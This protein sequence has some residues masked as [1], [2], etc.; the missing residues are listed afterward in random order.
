M[1]CAWLGPLNASAS[2]SAANTTKANLFGRF[3]LSTVMPHFLPSHSF[4]RQGVTGDSPILPQERDSRAGTL[5][6]PPEQPEEAGRHDAPIA[7]THQEVDGRQILL[8][9]ARSSRLTGVRCHIPVI[10]DDQD[11]R[12]ASRGYSFRAPLRV[13]IAPL[14][15]LIPPC[16][17]ATPYVFIVAPPLLLSIPRVSRIRFF[18]G[19][20]GGGDERLQGESGLPPALEPPAQRVAILEAVGSEAEGHPGARRLS[21]LRAVEDHLA[22]GWDQVVGVL[23]RFGSDP[24]R[25]RNSVRSRFDIQRHSQVNDH[26]VVAS[27]EPSLELHR[28]DASLP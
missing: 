5:T 20:S 25:P 24:V 19:K 26:E 14:P 3:C 12:V 10:P 22:V 13:E 28:G 23:Q 21:G 16:Q 7:A 11:R 15:S 9:P 17:A 4:G 1:A 6:A 27:V 8:W 2:A 18:A